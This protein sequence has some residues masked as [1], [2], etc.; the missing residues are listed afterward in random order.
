[1]GMI[2]NEQGLVAICNYN[3][4]P[5]PYTQPAHAVSLGWVEESKVP[6]LLAE[7]V[8]ACCGTHRLRYHLANANEV[9]V[10]LT[11]HL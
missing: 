2:K 8:R 9:S 6:Q 3:S 11:G 1:M 7:V 4:N 10:F 5:T